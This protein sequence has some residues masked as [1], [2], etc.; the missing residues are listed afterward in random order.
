MPLLHHAKNRFSCNA[1]LC[2]VRCERCPK[3]ALCA[4]E[5]ICTCPRYAYSNICKHIHILAIMDVNGA[6]CENIHPVD[7]V[8][9]L[10]EEHSNTA[11]K[12]SET[13]EKVGVVNV[14]SAKDKDGN[15]FEMTGKTASFLAE[16][17]KVDAAMR[18][19]R[20]VVKSNDYP[21]QEKT[22]FMESFKKPFADLVNTPRFLN[23]ISF[24]RLDCK[25]VHDPQK[26][27]SSLPVIT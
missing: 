14:Q 5:Y 16:C 21:L 11:G 12:R 18:E 9:S 26:L 1:A 3:D 20:N 4:H 13:G 7:E 15:N 19:I 10:S 2:L 17:D 6:S 27:F 24:L 23:P 25:R 8:D 22:M